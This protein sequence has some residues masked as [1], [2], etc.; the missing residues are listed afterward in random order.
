MMKADNPSS[1]TKR[2][3]IWIDLDNTPHVPF[4]AP[5]MAELERRGYS[6][7]LTARDCFQVCGLADLFDFKYLRVGRHYGKH[8]IMKAFG[9]TYR[10]FQ[11]LPLALRE[12]PDLAVSHG[13]R[14][15]LLAATM[16][17]IPSI[18]I[19]D[20]EFAKPVPGFAPTWVM[21]PEVIPNSSVHFGG[22]RILKYPGI[23]EDVYVPN[24]EPD[25]SIL[26]ELGLSDSQLI[27]TVRPP[28]NEAHY[29]NP[30]SEALFDAV[31]DLLSHTENTKIVL[32]P[33][34][35]RQ[36]SAIRTSWSKVFSDRRMIIPGRAVDGLN[37]M[38]H[39]DLVISGG[40]TMNRE[41]A[42]LGVPVYSIFRGAIGAVD[43][44]LSETGRLVLLTS[45]KD[46]REKLDVSRR[47]RATGVQIPP[48][49]ALKSVVDH[50]ATVIGSGS[51]HKVGK[52]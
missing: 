19:V 11:L 51:T 43:R 31:I 7:F 45:I 2:K 32:V 25:P 20:Y 15:Q 1:S 48:K 47:H 27:V 16:A 14:S 37:L 8:K 24:F 38:W 4:F 35:E 40:G 9:T 13:S 17:R 36:A 12:K 41:A 30:E 23:K 42:A 26:T 6:V 33:R 10:S 21:V 46:V 50:I 39:S 52:G 44:Y 22:G 29:H 28:A 3:K 34:N 5:I 49:G 18:V